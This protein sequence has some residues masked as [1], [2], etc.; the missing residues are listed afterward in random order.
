V[1]APIV[2]NGNVASAAGCLSAQNLIGW[3]IEN[4]AD[5]TLRETVLSSIKPVGDGLYFQSQNLESLYS[6]S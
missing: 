6:R 2:I 5:T 3:V 4:L 1:E